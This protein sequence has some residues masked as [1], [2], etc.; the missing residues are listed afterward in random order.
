MPGGAIV[1]KGTTF[2]MNA[3]E[4]NHDAARYGPNAWSFQP[5]RFLESK[6]GLQHVAFGAG[7][8]ICPAVA[9]S[10]RLIR[11]LVTRLLLAFD[12]DA[13]KEPGRR[14]NNDPVMFS[15]VVTELVAHP[16]FYDCHFKV[17]D[18]AWLKSVVAQEQ[19][20]ALQ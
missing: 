14:P 2:I 15:D 17:R 8:R 19:A 16:R 13:S 20:A 10:N 6:P 7:S 9:I 11:A 3:Q 4:V 12:M 1:P 18:E 5:D